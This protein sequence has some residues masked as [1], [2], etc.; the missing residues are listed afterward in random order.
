M[1]C[2]ACGCLTKYV[3]IKGQNCSIPVG[4]DFPGWI[5]CQ[6][7][8]LCKECDSNQFSTQDKIQDSESD[9]IFIVSVGDGYRDRKNGQHSIGNFERNRATRWGVCKSLLC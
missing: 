5:A 1:H 4:E 3:C 8:A 7:V 6:Q 2:V 9:D